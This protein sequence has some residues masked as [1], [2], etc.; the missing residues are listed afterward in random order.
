MT[1]CIAGRYNIKARLGSG[2]FGEVYEGVTVCDGMPCA[3]KRE[4]RDAAQ[5]L[6]EEEYK[7]YEALGGSPNLPAIYEFGKDGGYVFLAMDLL[8]RSLEHLRN[9]CP[10]SLMSLKTVLML[11]DQMLTTIEFIH[12][13]G[14][15]FRDIKPE[16]FLVGK[17]SASTHIF[18]VDFGLAKRYV[19]PET[20]AHIEECEDVSSVVGT[21]RYCSARALLGQEQ[22]RRDDM[23]SLL[24]LW[25]YL[26]HGTLPWMG[27]DE[28]DFDKKCL[29]ISKRKMAI[30]PEILCAN[31]PVEFA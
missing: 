20:G 26:M 18:M 9:F 21:A 24:Y 25:L 31:L 2:S 23:E 11:A 4:R 29:E 19:D 22:S 27:I 14:F 16:N 3:V 1:G 12:R 15:V 10:N 7:I 28:G 30:P 13:K 17:G 6:L 5:R 8:G